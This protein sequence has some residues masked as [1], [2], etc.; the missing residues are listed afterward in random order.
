MGQ[1][2]TT[3]SMPEYDGKS[4]TI[5]PDDVG[6]AKSWWS[7]IKHLRE[8]KA[9]CLHLITTRDI[10]ASILGH[11]IGLQSEERDQIALRPDTFQI[12]Q[13]PPK[14]YRAVVLL[15]NGNLS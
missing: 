9:Q 6:D 5:V 13:L 7:R 15:V 10:L 11:T 3:N 2:S 12:I 1:Y 4:R 8:T 14:T